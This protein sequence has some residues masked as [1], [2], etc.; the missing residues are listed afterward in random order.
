MIY[1]VVSLSLLFVVLSPYITIK[2]HEA[3]HVKLLDPQKSAR[4]SMDWLEGKTKYRKGPYP[5]RNFM[6]SVNFP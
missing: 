4:K 2:P 5:M 3:T 1:C 6:V